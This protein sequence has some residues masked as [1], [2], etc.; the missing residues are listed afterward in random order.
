LRFTLHKDAAK[1]LIV[2][3]PLV[4]S[5]GS[6]STGGS[7]GGGG[8]GGGGGSSEGGGGSGS[9]DGVEFDGRWL[10][11]LA[12]SELQLQLQ[13]RC[14]SSALPTRSSSMRSTRSSSS[15]NACNSTRRSTRRTRSSSMCSTSSSKKTSKQRLVFHSALLFEMQQW[16]QRLVPTHITTLN[17]IHH[18]ALH[19]I[20]PQLRSD[21]TNMALFCGTLDHTLFQD[22]RLQFRTE[23]H[24][25]PMYVYTTSPRVSHEHTLA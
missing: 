1:E 11:G 24:L 15:S 14:R 13:R 9:D 5:C 18:N 22:F 7:G 21:H 4:G 17:T 20:E 19:Q 10:V 16:F 6:G 3:V 25:I 2:S 8:G 12:F 23:R